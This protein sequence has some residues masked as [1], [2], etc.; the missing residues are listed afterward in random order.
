MAM[1][2][3]GTI[4]GLTEQNL[5]DFIDRRATSLFTGAS[6]AFRA[7]VIEIVEPAITLT[8][9]RLVES[10]ESTFKRGGVRQ[11]AGNDDGA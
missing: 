9:G 6:D 3:G 2:A 8:T 11:D 5:I 4:G 7:R 10:A 1:M